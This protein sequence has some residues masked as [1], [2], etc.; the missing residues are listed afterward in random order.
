MNPS[1]VHRHRYGRLAVLATLCMVASSAFAG[2]DTAPARSALQLL[3]TRHQSQ[4]TLVALEGQ[5]S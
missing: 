5:G 1:L 2:F 4:F 3:L